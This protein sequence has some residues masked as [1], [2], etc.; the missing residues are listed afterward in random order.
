VVTVAV[1]LLEISPFFREFPTDKLVPAYGELLLKK[2]L[3]AK[4]VG[5]RIYLFIPKE[6]E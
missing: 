5:H 6:A 1:L 4:R 2:F 3:I